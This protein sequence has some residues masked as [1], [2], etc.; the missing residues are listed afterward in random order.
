M[1][2]SILV[3]LWESVLLF[4][5]CSNHVS[6]SLTLNPLLCFLFGWCLQTR[7]FR[8]C[9]L[10]GYLNT[11]LRYLEFKMAKRKQKLPTRLQARVVSCFFFVNMWLTV[12]KIPV[13]SCWR[14][15]LSMM[16][17]NSRPMDGFSRVIEYDRPQRTNAG[18]TSPTQSQ[19]LVTAGQNPPYSPRR[20]YRVPYRRKYT[21]TN[22]PAAL[23]SLSWLYP[24]DRFTDGFMS[25][26]HHPSA[27]VL[28]LF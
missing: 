19:S 1:F 26:N 2:S 7:I 18:Q 17:S 15:I 12:K 5:P 4:L 23:E 22:P 10:I 24:S 9:D 6:D 20:Q 21:N 13:V 8:L 14:W 16:S 25:P 11:P 27:S 28:K 3:T